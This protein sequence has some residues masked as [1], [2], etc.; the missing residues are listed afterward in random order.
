MAE[1]RARKFNPRVESAIAAASARYGIPESRLRAFVAIESGGNPGVTTG[2]YKGALQLSDREFSRYGGGNIYDP[3]DNINA[4]ALKLKAE[5]EDF[6]RKYGRDPSDGDLYLI[7]Q[8]GTGGAAAHWANPDQ[9][10]WKSMYSTGE[11]RQKGPGWAKQ[12]IWGNVP[13]PMRAKYGSVDNITSRD[14]TDLWNQRVAHFGGNGTAQPEG[15]FSPPPQD[16]PP[17]LQANYGRQPPEAPQVAA[18]Q[19]AADPTLKSAFAG[20]VEKPL[21]KMP[22]ALGGKDITIKGLAG[23]FGPV[24]SALGGGSDGQAAAD[25]AKAGAQANAQALSDEE[26]QQVAVLQ[27]MLQRRKRGAFA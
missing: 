27:N 1:A 22:E 2:S 4:G 25:L 17:V 16:I 6:K 9:P 5:A 24:A 18:A 19:P 11:G 3:S 7:H 21:G 12:A 13:T 20:F 15:A 23:S 8:Q 10:A 26:R 14:F